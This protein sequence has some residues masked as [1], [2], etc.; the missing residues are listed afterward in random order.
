MVGIGYV[1]RR[2]GVVLDTVPDFVVGG[3]SFRCFS[4]SESRRVWS[5]LF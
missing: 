4:S 5:W 3:W 2:N 1:E